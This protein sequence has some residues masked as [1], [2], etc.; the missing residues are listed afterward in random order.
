[1]ADDRSNALARCEL[2]HLP[3]YLADVV[4]IKFTWLCKAPRRKALL[5]STPV[6]LSVNVLYQSRDIH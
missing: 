3:T 4:S 2:C 6:D 1:V 5:G